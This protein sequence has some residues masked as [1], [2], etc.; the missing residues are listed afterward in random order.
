M[1]GTA[2][3]EGLGRDGHSECLNHL[4]QVLRA[5]P[6][7][8]EETAQADLHPQDSGLC[9]SEHEPP[10]LRGSVSHGGLSRGTLFSCHKGQN[11]PG[12]WPDCVRSKLPEF[13]GWAASRWDVLPSC[14]GSRACV[15]GFWGL[16][17]PPYVERSARV[18]VPPEPGAGV[19]APG[20][21]RSASRPPAPPA[22][23]ESDA[24]Q[25]IAEGG[26]ALEVICLGRT[27]TQRGP[28]PRGSPVPEVPQPRG[29]PNPGGTPAQEGPCPQT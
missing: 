4:P 24:R 20:H 18:E 19:R 23:G 11:A 7:D 1:R 8:T 26:H 27:P 5:N 15:R 10:N 21:L 14:E 9:A 3:G 17:R 12:S 28:R 6:T 25:G 2:S 13:G 16:W 22:A 29:G